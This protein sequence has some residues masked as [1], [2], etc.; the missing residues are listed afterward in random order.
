MVEPGKHTR[1]KSAL[2]DGEKVIPAIYQTLTDSE[3]YTV[4][5]D[6]YHEEV[7]EAMENECIDMRKGVDGRRDSGSKH[8]LLNMLTKKQ[9]RFPSF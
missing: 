8:K 4:F 2:R 6:N 1:P 9:T 3:A 7:R 5:K